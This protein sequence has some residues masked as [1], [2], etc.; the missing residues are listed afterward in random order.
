MNRDK[1]FSELKQKTDVSQVFLVA[2][3][4][5]GDWQKTALAL[6]LDVEF[7]EWLAETEG[8]KEKIKRVSVLS[9]G[10]KPG[11]WERAQNRCLNYIQAHRVRMLIDRVLIELV[12]LTPEELAEKFKSCDRHGK[13]NGVSAR[14]F[15]DL[16]AALDKVHM[17]SYMALGDSV[18]ERVK[19]TDEEGGDRS[20]ADLHASLIAALN[21]P[22][23]DNKASECLVA[24][25][26]QVISAAQPERKALGP[27]EV[28]DPGIP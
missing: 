19:R 17:L 4:T 16:S 1:E 24:E 22:N 15:S 21:A 5:V 6:D 12:K 25:A 10:G 8:W 23:L 11:D 18:G 3:A 20:V 13:P 26:A 27:G 7:V 14:F 9:K 2:M 28:A